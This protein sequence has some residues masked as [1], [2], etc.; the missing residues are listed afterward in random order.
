MQALESAFQ[1]IVENAEANCEVCLYEKRHPDSRR[2]GMP[3]HTCHATIVAAAEL[4]LT[5]CDEVNCLCDGQ[6]DLNRVRA[7]IKRLLEGENDGLS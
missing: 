2:T 6:D 4:G 5:V 3:P 1:K 7:T